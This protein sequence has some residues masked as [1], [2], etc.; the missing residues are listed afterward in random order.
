MQ[1]IPK[2][3]PVSFAM[4]HYLTQ[5]YAF[6]SGNCNITRFRKKSTRV[7]VPGSKFSDIQQDA[8]V[9]KPEA[10]EYVTQQAYTTVQTSILHW[11]EIAQ[12]KESYGCPVH[13]RRRTHFR[14]VIRMVHRWTAM[15][16]EPGRWFGGDPDG[17]SLRQSHRPNP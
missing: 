4:Y 15:A 1:A 13:G 9:N 16:L 6:Q 3:S 17:L 12:K 5:A 2:G 14:T 7:I 11:N 10:A 8:S